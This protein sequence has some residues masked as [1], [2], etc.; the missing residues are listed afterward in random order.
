MTST[1]NKDNK[2]L[3]DIYIRSYIHPICIY[4]NIYPNKCTICNQNIQHITNNPLNI[5]SIEYHNISY[6]NEPLS[7]DIIQFLNNNKQNIYNTYH[8]YLRKVV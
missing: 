4:G 7:P 2:N 3:L 1:L 6:H 5:K 8:A